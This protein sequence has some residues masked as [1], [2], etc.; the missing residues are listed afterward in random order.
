MTDHDQP[1]VI[2]RRLIGA[3]GASALGANA[4]A[5][6]QSA[7]G[8]V[9]FPKRQVRVVV[10]FAPGGATDLVGRLL[11]SKLSDAWGQSVIVENKAGASGIIGTEQVAR[12][13]ADGHTLL[14]AITTHIQN[15]S[16]FLKLPFDPYRDF[17]AVSQICLSYLVLVV[18]PDF[19]ANTLKEFVAYCKTHPGTYTFGSFGTAS[20]SHVVGE[21]FGRE[22]GLQVNHV[23]Y[24]GSSPML[25]DLLGGQI[26]VGWADVSTATA[27]IAAGR[28]K[29]LAVSGPARAPMLPNVPTLAESGYPG[30]EPLGWVG[31]LVAAGTPRP[32]VDVIARE[33]I[34]ITNLPDVKQ[35]LQEQTLVPVGSTPEAF[36]RTLREDGA[37]WA[38]MIQNAGITP[39]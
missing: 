4:P 37:L 36:A 16:L 12:A 32:V 33:V 17:T 5:W 35:R 18:K 26:K 29:P 13:P 6:A 7:G 31:V 28:L 34:R 2:R 14:V 21:G 22:A 8:A 9:D 24:K 1:S 30:F 38:R 20:S 11:A 3:V 25:T 10:P 27:H 39:Q 19:P 23:A 15:P